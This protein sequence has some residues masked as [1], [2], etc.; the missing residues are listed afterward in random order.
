MAKWNDA[1]EAFNE[2]TEY[3][4]ASIRR[5]PD[6]DTCL[7]SLSEVEAETLHG[8][9]FSDDAWVEYEAAVER[10]VET[11][12]Q[13]CRTLYRLVCVLAA[14]CYPNP[15]TYN[16]TLGTLPVL[17]DE[18]L[19]TL[20][21]PQVRQLIVEFQSQTCFNLNVGDW[22]E[23]TEPYSS[24]T[25]FFETI[26]KILRGWR[27]E[28]T[29]APVLDR[30]RWQP[31]EPGANNLGVL[32]FRGTSAPVARQGKVIATVLQAFEDGS[33]EQPVPFPDGKVPRGVLQSLK[34]W[35]MNNELSMTFASEK[36]GNHF[37]CRWHPSEET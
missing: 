9:P 15:A 20:V 13:P 37:V 21:I 22:F 36:Q 14:V 19:I 27:G 26:G 28:V 18:H 8:S 2:L 16:T 30:P 25:Q 33:W 31:A 10:F 24:A 11:F 12:D 32:S 23:I 5:N 3:D 34:N 6:F 4:W 35:A 7:P 1:R 29:V 17:D